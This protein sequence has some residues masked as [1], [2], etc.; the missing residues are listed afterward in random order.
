MVDLAAICAEQA[1]AAAA[2]MAIAKAEIADPNQRPRGGDVWPIKKITGKI[3]DDLR[4]ADRAQ[5][6]RRAGTLKHITTDVGGKRDRRNDLVTSRREVDGSTTSGRN[7]V[8]AR[9]NSAG[10]V[11]AS[12]CR[13]VGI[14]LRAIVFDVEDVSP[15]RRWRSLGGRSSRSRQ[16]QDIFK[17]S[18]QDIT[19][20]LPGSSTTR[21]PRSSIT[22]DP[23]LPCVQPMRT[24][25]ESNAVNN[26]R[27]IMRPSPKRRSL[28]RWLRLIRRCCSRTEYR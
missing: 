24:K 17:N 26:L 20:W 13:Y 4:A 1:D 10:I 7:R 2:G 22:L 14:A 27:V 6:V 9:L 15:S 25:D 11:S 21:L 28:A 23:P 18:T 5:H 19:T 3:P 8:N 16:K 12:R